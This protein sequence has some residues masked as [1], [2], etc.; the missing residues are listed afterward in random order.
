MPFEELQIF[1]LI[2][3]AIKRDWVTQGFHALDHTPLFV[4]LVESH[5]EHRSLSLVNY[6]LYFVVLDHL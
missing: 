5:K 1:L 6:I 2:D 4:L 3:D